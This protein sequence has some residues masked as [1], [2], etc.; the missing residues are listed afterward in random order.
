MQDVPSFSSRF[1]SC[2]CS[3]N[4]DF[5]CDP[6]EEV[7]ILFVFFF[8]CRGPAWLGFWFLLYYFFVFPFLSFHFFFGLFLFL[9]FFSSCF[10]FFFW[11][12]PLFSLLFY[13]FFLFP[14]FIPFFFLLSFS[15]RTSLCFTSLFYYL[16]I[17]WFAICLT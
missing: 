12:F 15:S 16:A 5:Y 10:Y 13:S 2:I 7:I 9:F 1:S 14:F 3:G 11:F 17:F 6:S 8:T 4:I